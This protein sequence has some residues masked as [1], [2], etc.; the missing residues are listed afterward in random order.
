M[1][2]AM[3]FGGVRRTP[4]ANGGF[5]HVPRALHQP[6]LVNALGHGVLGHGACRLKCDVGRVDECGALH[7]RELDLV[8]EVIED[9][10]V[11]GDYDV[12]TAQYSTTQNEQNI[13]NERSEPYT[14]NKTI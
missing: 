4:K 12:A 13:A 14:F 8:A 9:V 1:R 5:P 11:G 6:R 2:L 3:S 10:G 7:R